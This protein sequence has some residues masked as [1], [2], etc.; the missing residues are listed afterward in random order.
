MILRKPHN[1]VLL[2]CDQLR[3]RGGSVVCLRWLDHIPAPLPPSSLQSLSLALP[4]PFCFL[5]FP[6]LHLAHLP[7]PNLKPIQD[8]RCWDSGEKAHHPRPAAAL[9]V[10]APLGCS[11]SGR[12]CAPGKRSLPPLTCKSQPVGHFSC[13][14]PSR[15]PLYPHSLYGKRIPAKSGRTFIQGQILELAFSSSLLGFE[16]WECARNCAKPRKSAETGRAV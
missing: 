3:T 2:L 14:L 16:R 12:P 6:T 5:S 8:L 10:H 11:P 9:D 13:L 4:F 15:L 7:S 1:L